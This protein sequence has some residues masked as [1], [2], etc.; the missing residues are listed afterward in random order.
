VTE[1]ATTTTT[2]SSQN[3]SNASNSLSNFIRRLSQVSITFRDT[4]IG[5]CLRVVY[6]VTMNSMHKISPEA[7]AA[8]VDNLEIERK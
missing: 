3:H 7:K 6:V 5:L 2:I 4:E 8:M 1:T